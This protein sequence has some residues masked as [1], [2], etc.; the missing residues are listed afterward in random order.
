MRYLKDHRT[1]SLATNHTCVI[2]HLNVQWKI[3]HMGLYIHRISL[4]RYTKKLAMVFVSKKLGE[5][6]RSKRVTYT[7]FNVH[8]FLYHSWPLNIMGLNCM[9]PYVAFFSEYILQFYTIHGWVNLQMWNCGYQ[10]PSTKLYAHFWLCGGLVPQP[11]CCSWGNCIW[12]YFFQPP[13][14]TLPQLINAK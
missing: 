2:R 8:T 14:Y 12:F 9:G 5:W 7:L 13:V 6:R 4:E 11:P 3:C 1:E 10:G